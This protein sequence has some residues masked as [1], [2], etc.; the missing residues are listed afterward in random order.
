MSVSTYTIQKNLVGKKVEITVGD[1]MTPVE[2]ERFGKEFASTIASI[3]AA[4]FQLVIDST[5]MK[6]LTPEMATKLEG[7]MALYNQA[8]FS[9]ILVRLQ[10]NPVLKMQVSRIARKVG[11]TSFEIIE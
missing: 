9:K 5:N 7:A 11:L 1:R 6:V 10:N 3:N 2:A 8:G 4:Q